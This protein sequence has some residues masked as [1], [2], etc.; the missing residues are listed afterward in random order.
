M[1]DTLLF[2]QL[3]HNGR[4][5]NCGVQDVNGKARRLM[6]KLIDRKLIMPKSLFITDITFKSHLDPVVVAPIGSVFKGDHKG[7]HIVL[8]LVYK[9]HKDVSSQFLLN[10]CSNTNSLAPKNVVRKKLCREALTWQSLSHRFILP[11]LGIFEEK[12]QLLLVSPFMM[13][14]NLA[15]WRKNSTPAMAELHRPV[16]L[17]PSQNS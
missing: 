13:N 6:F 12:S 4:L 2:H 15:Q 8:K 1:L 9:G 3:L 5:S 14:G 7:K 11:M 16:R 10:F 17:H